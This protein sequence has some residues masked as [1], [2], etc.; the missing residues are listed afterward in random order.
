MLSTTLGFLGIVFGLGFVIFVHELGHFLV[1]K[2]AGIR[3]D[4]FAIG[5]GQALFSYRQGSGFQVGSSGPAVRQKVRDWLADA[6]RLPDDKRKNDEIEIPPQDVDDAL[7]ALGLGETEYRFNWIPLGGYVKM[8]GQE[9][10]DPSATSDYSRSY[11]Q[12]SISA[13]MGVVSAGVI[14]NMIFA[15]IFFIAAFLIGVSFPPPIVG[16]TQPGLPAATTPAEE[17]PSLIGLEPGDRVITVNGKRPVDFADVMFYIALAPPDEPVVLVVE[18]PGEIGEEPQRLTFHV[19]RELDERMGVYLAGFEPTRKLELVPPLAPNLEVFEQAGLT[20]LG[21]QPGY[22]ISSVNGIPV[23]PNDYFRYHR[24]LQKSAGQPITLTLTRTTAETGPET[25]TATITPETVLQ[26]TDED[27]RIATP[28]LLGLVPPTEVRAINPGSPA[29]GNLKINDIIVSIDTVAWPTLRQIAPI[30]QASTGPLNITVLRDGERVEMQITP[31]NGLIGMQMS[32]ATSTN[33]VAA[34]LPDTLF[35]NDAWQLPTSGI[36]IIRIGE[37]S[38][39]SYDEIRHALLDARGEIEIEIVVPQAEPETHTLTVPEA[40]RRAIA[41]LGWADPLRP[42][43]MELEEIQKASNPIEALSMGTRKTIQFGGSVY[44]TIARLFQ[45]TVQMKSLSGPVGIAVMGT[46]ISQRGFAYLLFF[47]GVISVSLAVINFLPLPIVD[48]GLA[49]L[50]LYEK[51]RGKPA[52]AAIQVG[53]AYVGLALL[54]T[55]FVV[56]TYN[57]IF[58]HIIGR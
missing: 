44:L 28:H 11:N 32:T 58:T 21:L 20:E 56:V 22:A 23:Q 2:W 37:Q 39:S 53:I 57:D 24:Q 29:D 27:P 7:K 41:A 34:I 43:F 54:G 16:S 4:Q 12:K 14:M 18:R 47:L 36:Q 13:R 17:D 6:G 26:T 25:L 33:I 46:R 30:V 45:G 15:V 8:L 50:L 9:D 31:E 19:N 38:V 1:A 10:L 49:V 35:A 48:G 55:L 51:I 3:C 52:S 42:F 5:F 40:D